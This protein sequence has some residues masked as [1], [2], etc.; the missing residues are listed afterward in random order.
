MLDVHCIAHREALAANDASSHF[1][2]LQF[3]DKFANK[4]YSWLG[5]SSKRH[6]E[7]KEL[8]ESFQI[9]KLEILQIHQIR[10]LSRGKVMEILAKLMPALLKDWELGEKKMYE[11]ATIFQ[12]QFYIHLLADVLIEL[13]KF[14]QKFQEDHVDITSIGTTLDVSIS[15]LRKRFL[16]DIFGA[17]AV[18]ISSFL[19]KV[20][21]ETLEVYR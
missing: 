4:V 19:S 16:G 7:L 2:E 6:G 9:T 5:K 1:L 12:V 8:M 17:G 15:M 10:W 21:G 11:L 13:N 20:Q 18:N 14:N 3:I